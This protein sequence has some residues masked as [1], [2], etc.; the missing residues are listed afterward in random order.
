VNNAFG[1]YTSERPGKAKEMA[2]GGTG[3]AE[4]GS[5][6]VFKGTYYV[7]L[8][9]SGLGEE[10]ESTLPEWAEMIAGCLEG[11]AG[12]PPTAACFPKDSLVANSV[13]YVARGFLGHGFLHSAFAAEYTEGESEFR[14]FIIE[15]ASKAEAKEMLD[16]YLELAREKGE[17]PALDGNTH[18][19][20]DPYRSSQGMVSIREQDR[21]LVGVFHD[22][23]E[24]ADE[25][26]QQMV[27][28]L[29][30]PAD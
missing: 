3:Y 20:H 16:A 1:I 10:E 22:R 27:D 19:F 18:R 11:R 25:Y 23:T 26:L 7:K 15:A 28:N 14:A 17:E 6:N 29:T 12:L 5:F 24:L 9:A 8:K 13:R 2:L 21:F 30:R 4:A